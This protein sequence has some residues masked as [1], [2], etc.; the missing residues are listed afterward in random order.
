MKR[1]LITLLLGVVL[2]SPLAWADVSVK[3]PSI[4]RKEKA[5]RKKTTETRKGTRRFRAFEAFS[6][7]DEKLDAA[8]EAKD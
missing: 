5:A 3:A 4:D 2:V 7:P 8:F 6:V 1:I